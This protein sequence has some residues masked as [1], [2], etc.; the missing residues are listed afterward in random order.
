MV[1]SKEEFILS[2]IYLN[3]S[4]ASKGKSTSSSARMKRMIYTGALYSSNEI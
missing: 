1:I 4:K 3:H 2:F